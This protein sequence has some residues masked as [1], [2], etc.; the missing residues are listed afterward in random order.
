MLQT[1]NMKQ[2]VIIQK[3]STTRKLQF[4]NKLL[5]MGDYVV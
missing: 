5:L 1:S 4:T 3:Q 2:S